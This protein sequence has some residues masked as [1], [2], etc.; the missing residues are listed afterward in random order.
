MK[1]LSLTSSGPIIRIAPNELHINDVSFLDTIYPTSNSHVRDKDWNQTRGLD[2]GESTSGT[3]SHE[4]HRRRREALSPFFT[5]KN[6]V[7]LEPLIEG[8]VAQLC[9][10]LD[11]AIVSKTPVNLYDLYYAVAR[12]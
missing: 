7:T 10:H 1:F 4:L 11:S 3:I 6:V 5:Q 2:V 12:E 8:K 9:G